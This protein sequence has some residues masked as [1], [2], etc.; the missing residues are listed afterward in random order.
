MTDAYARPKWWQWRLE[1]RLRR[2]QL[3]LTLDDLKAPVPFAK[4][5][6]L[7]AIV[8]MIA[9]FIVFF[10]NWVFGWF[11][12]PLFTQ[13]FWIFVAYM[14]ISMI[15]LSAVAMYR[16]VQNHWADTIRVHVGPSHDMSAADFTPGKT[17]DS[18]DLA[19][20][21]AVDSP[22]EKVDVELILHGG[23][24]G[25]PEK[26]PGLRRGRYVTIARATVKTKEGKLQAGH[27]EG[28]RYH[29]HAK[30]DPVVAGDAYNWRAVDWFGLARKHFGRRIT[31]RTILVLGLEPMDVE[32][33]EVPADDPTIRRELYEAKQR[34]RSLESSLDNYQHRDHRR[35]SWG[36]EPA[37]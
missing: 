9:N 28:N 27:L 17:M 1:H 36:R 26:F 16:L 31:V 18:V 34:V 3:S 23:V 20:T 5:L 7:S 29:V 14:A 35:E 13:G 19:K 22:K 6:S 4:F 12:A 33:W 8:W 21:D 25:L 30:P 11:P 2:K 32:T 24:T 10:W 15:F 37:A